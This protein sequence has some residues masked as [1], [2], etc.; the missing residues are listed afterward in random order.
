[1]VGAYSGNHGRV[2]AGE[3][4]EE[5][6][7]ECDARFLSVMRYG[8]PWDISYPECDVECQSRDEG[9]GRR[10]THITSS[11]TNY[12]LRVHRAVQGSAAN[13]MHTTKIPRMLNSKMK[14]CWMGLR[15]TNGVGGRLG[16]SDAWT[17]TPT[18]QRDD[19]EKGTC[20]EPLVNEYGCLQTSRYC[21][22]L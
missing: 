11:T 17:R 5:S 22:L 21:F 18:Y 13:R 9:T 1:M 2:G 12:D 6:N 16:I 20:H 8:R 4:R 10:S 7:T 15:N 3:V 14:I 19:R